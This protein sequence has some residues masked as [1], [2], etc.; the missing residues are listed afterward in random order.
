MSLLHA[1]REVVY[2]HLRFLPS[3]KQASVTRLSVSAL[4]SRPIG[5]R[6]KRKKYSSSLRG[7]LGLL[8]PRVRN[9]QCFVA[10]C[11][12][13]SME[14]ERNADGSFRMLAVWLRWRTSNA[15]LWATTH[16]PTANTA[17]TSAKNSASSGF[18]STPSLLTLLMEMPWALKA[19]E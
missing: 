14:A 9:P 3:M 2:H 15:V 1:K 5:L 10:P 8:F 6:L 16:T 13:Q 7:A 17:A 12:V 4:W 11:M 18:G 19:I